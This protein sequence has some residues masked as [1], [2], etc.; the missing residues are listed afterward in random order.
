MGPAVNF[1]MSGS[2]SN[3]LSVPRLKDD[4]SNWVDYE[5]KI[6]T[7]MGAKGLI[8]HVEGTAQAPQPYAL[9]NGVQ[10]TKPGTP[11]T[12]DEIEA[13]EKKLDEFEQKQYMARH[14]IQSTI[15]PRLAS[16]VKT[17]TAKEMEAVT[18]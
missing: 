17:K 9:E 6:R 11:A 12:D 1:E 14:F 4:D 16:L 5:D 8:R 7:A 3:A 15:S 18:K 2:S 10:V 13:K